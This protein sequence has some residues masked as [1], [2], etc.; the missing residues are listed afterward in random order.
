MREQLV[1][2]SFADSTRGIEYPYGHFGY[3]AMQ[4]ESDKRSNDP[5]RVYDDLILFSEEAA[6]IGYGMENLSSVGDALVVTYFLNGL[7]AGPKKLPIEK[8]VA[9]AESGG[10]KNENY[11]G[12]QNGT[13]EKWFD[14]FKLNVG[15][16]SKAIY[17][18]EEVIKGVRN[19]DVFSAYVMLV[20][21]EAYYGVK[22]LH[23][24]HYIVFMGVRCSQAVVFDPRVGVNMEHTFDEIMN[25]SERVWKI[26]D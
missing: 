20:R 16:H 17:E 18:A 22:K 2:K 13:H 14:H 6:Q 21:D 15:L 24:F 8:I 19:M 23:Q 25:A 12:R 9:I 5:K 4:Y 11:A 3:S 1:K 10:Y 26:T 7:F